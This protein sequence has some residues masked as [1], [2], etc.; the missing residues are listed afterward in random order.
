[1]ITDFLFWLL[2]LQKSSVSCYLLPI[3]FR[4]GE[5]IMDK[6]TFLIQ[7]ASCFTER[8]VDNLASRAIHGGLDED[9]VMRAAD[10]RLATLLMCDIDDGYGQQFDATREYTSHTSHTGLQGFM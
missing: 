2:T 8:E 6:A 9:Q 5:H 10:D 7:L 4:Q 1:M 3:N